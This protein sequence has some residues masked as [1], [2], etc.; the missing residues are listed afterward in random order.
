MSAT[1][2]TYQGLGS[3]L[4]VRDIDRNLLIDDVKVTKD[5]LLFP[6]E[7]SMA[8]RHYDVISHQIPTD[9]PDR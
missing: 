3:A 8:F 9:F 1:K 4:I 6:I 2:P 5:P 7:K